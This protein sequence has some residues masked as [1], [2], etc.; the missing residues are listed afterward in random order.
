MYGSSLERNIQM[1]TMHEPSLITYQ[2]R[3]N[4]MY[5]NACI[6]PTYTYDV[7]Y[8]TFEELFLLNHRSTHV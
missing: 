1:M 3:E 2:L 7:I 8:R 4:N 5:L 6:V